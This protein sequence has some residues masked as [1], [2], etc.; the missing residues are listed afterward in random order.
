MAILDEAHPQ[1]KS[2]E[3]KLKRGIEIV[4]TGLIVGLASPVFGGPN[5]GEPAPDFTEPDTAGVDR[6]LSE[7]AG[8]AVLVNFWTSW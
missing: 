8:K 4:V 7:F 1:Q 2:R 3:S 6:S 5:V